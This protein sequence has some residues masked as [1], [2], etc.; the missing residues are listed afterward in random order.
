[1]QEEA[2][3]LPLLPGSTQTWRTYVS[4]SDGIGVVAE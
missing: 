1:V 4:I 2:H 3:T